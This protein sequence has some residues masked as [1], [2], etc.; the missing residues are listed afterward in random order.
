[1]GYMSLSPCL[2]AT[3]ADRKNTIIT[4]SLI[5]FVSLV[6]NQNLFFSL[7]GKH[8]Q[9]NDDRK[10]KWHKNVSAQRSTMGLRASALFVALTGYTRPSSPSSKSIL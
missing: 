6:E 10:K 5:N 4:T 3:V 8:Q 1:V 7:I 2:N 9:D